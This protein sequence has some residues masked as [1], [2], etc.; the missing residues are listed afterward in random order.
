MN[1][2]ILAITAFVLTGCT[3]IPVGTIAV[4]VGVCRYKIEATPPQS[5]SEKLGA[6]LGGLA[7]QFLLKSKQP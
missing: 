2:A 6:D 5:A 3:T 1:R 7:A 4:C